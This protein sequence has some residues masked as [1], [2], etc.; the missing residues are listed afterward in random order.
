MPSFGPIR[1]RDLID[2]LQ[3]AGFDGPYSGGK[4]QFLIRRQDNHRL[5]LPNPHMSDIGVG[6]LSR[7]LKQAGIERST[8][9]KL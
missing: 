9:E 5:V 2:C 6:L 8:W 4:H 1:R 7:I 3:R